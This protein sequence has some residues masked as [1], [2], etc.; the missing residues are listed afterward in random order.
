MKQFKQTILFTLLMSMVG[1][2]AFAYDAKIDGIYY[3]FSGTEATVTYFSISSDRNKDAYSGNVVIPESVTYNGTTYSV[4][5]IGQYAF[6]NCSGLTS[7]TIGNSVTSIGYDAFL[8]CSSLTSVDIPNSVTSI[9]SSA[10]SGC[11]SLTSVTI[12]NS[13]TSIEYDAFRYCSGL[14]SVTIPNSVTSIG[15]SAF[16]GTHL[17]SITI[18]SGVLSLG[19]YALGSPTKVIWLTNTPPSGYGNAAGTVN[20]VANNL[21]TQLSNKT[22]YPFLSSLFEVG[23]VKYVPV[24]PSDRTCDAIDCVYGDEAENVNIGEKVS[25]RGIQMTVEKVQPYTCYQNKNIKSVEL[26][27]GGDLGKEA[28]RGCTSITQTTV[29]NNGT[30]GESAFRDCTGIESLSIGDQVT[31]IMNYAFSGC[32]IETATA[33][34]DNHGTIGN[35]SFESSKIQHVTLGEKITSIGSSCF[36]YCSK[37]ESIVIPDAVATIGER[38]FSGC[39]KM[40]SAK[41]GTGVKTIAESTFS[42]CSSLTD[43]QIGSKVKQINDYAFR[44]CNSLQEISIPSAITTIKDYVFQN[45]SSLKNVLIDDSKTVL[46]LGANGSS[47]MFSSC[48]LDSVYIGRNIS[49]DTSSD[50]GYSPFYRN[51]SLRTVVITDKETEISENEFYGCTNLQDVKIG[52]GVKSFGNWA[53]SGC[54]NL[55]NFSFGMSVKTIGK[56][57]FSDCTAMERIFSRSPQPPTCGSQALDDINKWNCVLTVPA[58]NVAAYKAADQWKEFFFIE[59]GETVTFTLTYLVDGEEYKSMQIGYGATITPEPAPEKEGFSFSG[60]SGLP[61]T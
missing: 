4:T 16:S 60:W 48:P 58:G 8:N 56:E 61:D 12:G 27:F 53:F 52:D 2:T 20:Y 17:N 51:T 45:C 40:T 24:S 9:G 21:Y 25:Y 22:E 23:G 19:N 1:A 28:F 38:A 10:F 46:S 43:M 5:G 42:G 31:N 59:E 55:R 11:S 32:C 15:S 14:T 6:R 39:S 49:Y 35:Y 26:T 44:D 37:L 29:N 33:T 3:E 47:P 36:A 57:A 54:S 7:V 41:M 50:K 13:V 18:G 30:I 34:I